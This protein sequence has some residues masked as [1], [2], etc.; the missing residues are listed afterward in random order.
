VAKTEVFPEPEVWQSGRARFGARVFSSEISPRHF[1][2]LA[3]E[4]DFETLPVDAEIID[5]LLPAGIKPHRR[6]DESAV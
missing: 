4:L 1:A 3:S 6:L 2:L 5:D